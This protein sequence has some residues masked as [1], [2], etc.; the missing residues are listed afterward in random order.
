MIEGIDQLNFPEYC[1]MSYEQASREA[2]R[3][4]ERAGWFQGFERLC[5]LHEIMKFTKRDAKH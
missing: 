2:T 1:G 4:I 5:A 3:L